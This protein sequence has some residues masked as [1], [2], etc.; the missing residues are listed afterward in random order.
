M[1]SQLASNHWATGTDCQQPH[2][3]VPSATDYNNNKYFWTSV[4][5]CPHAIAFLLQ[6]YL[7]AIRETKV[8]Y[9]TIYN[10]L[11]TCEVY[12]R[13]QLHVMLQMGRHYQ[14]CL[15]YI[16]AMVDKGVYCTKMMVVNGFED[17]KINVMP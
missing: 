16:K 17:T 6:T 13:W 5:Y 14:T 15:R 11:H 12:G 7:K 10:W 9:Q 4:L 3:L 2:S 8:S 1:I